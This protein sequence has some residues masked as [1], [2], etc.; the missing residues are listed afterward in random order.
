MVWGWKLDEPKA[1]LSAANK[2]HTCFGRALNHSG[3]SLC[4]AASRKL[5]SYLFLNNFL[6]SILEWIFKLEVMKAS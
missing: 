5:P 6:I 4:K 3:F 1:D 2:V